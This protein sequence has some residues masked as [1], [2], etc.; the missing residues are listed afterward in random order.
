MSLHDMRRQISLASA[1]SVWK[2]FMRMREPVSRLSYGNGAWTNEVSFF[3]LI[4]QRA[5]NLCYGAFVIMKNDYYWEKVGFILKSETL[6][7]RVTSEF[8]KMEVVL[9]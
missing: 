3:F 2:R 8:A 6:N 5:I 4:C 9:L 7:R 1:R